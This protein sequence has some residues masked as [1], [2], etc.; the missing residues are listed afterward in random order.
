MPLD[1]ESLLST[2]QT[3][4]AT[5]DAE[6]KPTATPPRAESPHTER[7]YAL[8]QRL[9]T[10]DYWT[11]TNSSYPSLALEGKDLTTTG[12]AYAE[13][14]SIFPSAP[15]SEY[16]PTLGSYIKK[17]PPVLGIEQEARR[18]S[19]GKFLDYGPFASF[20][21]TFD[22]DGVEVG[23][24]TLSEV[25]WYQQLDKRRNSVSALRKQMEG[26][27]PAVATEE[28]SEVIEVTNPFSAPLVVAE[29][30]DIRPSLDGL[31]SPEQVAGVKKALGSLELERAVEELLQRNA[32]A[33]ATLERLQAERLIGKDG[34]KDVEVGSEEWDTGTVLKPHVGLY[35]SIGSPQ[36]KASS[37]H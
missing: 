28:I 32:R 5:D 7:K 19:S 34:Y 24:R 6:P 13:L 20:A 33:L 25:V 23:Q 9:P 16:K 36:H 11:S 4:D 10:G 3:Q 17:R 18:L 37:I 15:V 14:V 1:V 31:L 22:Q 30:S 12:T 8:V 21:P 29:S 35:V 26:Q 2:N 27:E